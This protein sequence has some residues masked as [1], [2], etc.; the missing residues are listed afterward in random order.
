MDQELLKDFILEATEGLDCLDQDLLALEQDNNNPTTI[1][2]IF[3][4][5]HTIK[6]T[7]GFLELTKIEQLSHIGETLLD[8]IRND[9]VSMDSQVISALL[10]MLD[11]IRTMLVCLETENNEGN[12][13]YSDLIKELK[14]LNDRKK[15]HTAEQTKQLQPVSERVVDELEELFLLAQKEY[16]VNQNLEDNVQVDK[17]NSVLQENKSDQSISNK[18]TDV[19]SNTAIADKQKVT[20][21]SLRVDLELIDRLM[22]LVGELVLTRNQILTNNHN[23]TLLTQTAQRLN[24]ITSELQE[25]IMRTRMQ[26]IINVWS[27]LPRVVRDIAKMCDKEVVVEMK[28][29]DTDLDKTI[30]E[31]I[32][33]PLTHIIRNAVDHGIESP[34]MREAHGKSRQGKI[35]LSAG[36]EGGNV[37]IEIS[38]NGAGINIGKVRKK[39]L[40]K[41]LF[42][43]DKLDQM[44]DK[45][46]QMLVFHPGFSTAEQISNISGRGVGMDVVRSNLEQIGGSIELNSIVGKGTNLKIKI[47]MTLAIIPAL[48]IS[49]SEQQF[50]IPQTDLVEI[51]RIEGEE[52]FTQIEEVGNS[53]FIR[54]RGQL[55]PIVYLGQQLNL[56][57]R[58]TNTD[59]GYKEKLACI[60]VIV[61]N[62]EDRQFGLVVDEVHE[63]Q[64]IVV[65]PLSNKLKNSKVFRGSTIMGDGKLALI[66]DSYGIAQASSILDEYEHINKKESENNTSEENKV[67]LLVAD[68]GQERRIAVELNKVNR[69]EKFAP[70]QVEYGSGYKV[71][72]YRD[73]LLRLINLC[74]DKSDHTID[75]ETGELKVIVLNSESNGLGLIVN[76]FMD[77]V[78]E[79]IKLHTWKPYPGVLGSTVV[80]GKVTDLIDLN[81]YEELNN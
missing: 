47:P 78:D 20:D 58:P 60:T 45:D 3:R 1:N 46:I 10:K 37:I 68:I 70:S 33:D 74:D 49:Q 15:N 25:N 48:I 67:S 35:S 40:E 80:Q 57:I 63:F 51:F 12:N 5:I 4:R 50:A 32:K 59:N 16:Q 23:D 79:S 71:I 54:L 7:C 43:Q 62:I 61:I 19:A 39:A 81:Y 66:I 69:L 29:E 75:N 44:S 30:I 24:I 38:D 56:N 22:N 11:A 72:N 6:G 34:D 73:G 41:G 21:S 53:I 76:N 13:D 18:N 64:E 17:E 14:Q 31:A 8:S 9:L 26:P 2:S 65:K 52:L 55:L 42:S 36:H 77:I 27:K 28:G